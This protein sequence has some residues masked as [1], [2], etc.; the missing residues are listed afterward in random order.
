MT[1]KLSKHKKKT[2]LKPHVTVQT[3]TSFLDSLDSLSGPLTYGLTNDYMFRA[4]FQENEEALHGL[5]CAL[6]DLSWEQIVNITILNPIIL[7]EAINEKTIVL[8]LNS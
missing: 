2:I 7:G 8:D 3:S 1:K 4:V 6:L 5:L